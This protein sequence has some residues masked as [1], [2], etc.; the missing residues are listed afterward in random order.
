LLAASGAFLPQ[1]IPSIANHPKPYDYEHNITPHDA[2]ILKHFL[3]LAEFLSPVA[4]W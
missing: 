1:T 2:L 3:E 4:Q